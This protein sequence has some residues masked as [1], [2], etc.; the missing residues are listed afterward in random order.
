M[1]DYSL[2]QLFIA[3]SRQCMKGTATLERSDALVVFAFEEKPNLRPRWS[4]T[5]ECGANEG[6]G[7]LWC[8]CEV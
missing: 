8:G 5:F 7:G 4:L 3:Q 1:C 6:F 2:A